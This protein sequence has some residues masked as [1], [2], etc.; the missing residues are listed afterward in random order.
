MTEKFK[1]EP[2]TWYAWQMLPGY[3][4]E[5]YYSPIYVQKVTPL[6][7]GKNLLKVEFINAFYA[8]GV[9]G[10]ELEMKVLKREHRYMILD[11]LYDQRAAIITD[12]N[13]QWIQKHGLLMLEKEGRDKVPKLSGENVQEFLSAFFTGNPQHH[14]EDRRAADAS[15]YS[16]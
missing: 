2:F 7:T 13:Y 1:L 9:K 15:G 11:L 6:K 14:I 5:F 3:T 8:S 12:I 16:T 10:F 4:D